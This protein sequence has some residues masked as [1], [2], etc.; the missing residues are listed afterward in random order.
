MKILG[1]SYHL[2][3][4]QLTTSFVDQLTFFFQR[5]N[6]RMNNVHRTVE[7]AHTSDTRHLHFLNCSIT[8]R[9]IHKPIYIINR[10]P[11]YLYDIQEI[12]KKNTF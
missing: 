4:Y 9:P 3:A 2:S 8:F 11:K 1:D 12:E 7:R 6:L 10:L 5:I